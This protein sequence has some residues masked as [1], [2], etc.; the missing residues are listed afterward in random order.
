MR[1]PVDTFEGTLSLGVIELKFLLVLEFELLVDNSFKLPSDSLDL[2]DHLVLL[3]R[4]VIPLLYLL[5][6]NQ[7]VSLFPVVAIIS[8]V[9][10][11][12]PIFISAIAF[13]FLL[14]LE[15]QY[16]LFIVETHAPRDTFLFLASHSLHVRLN[17]TLH[18]L[19]KFSNLVYSLLH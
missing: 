7:L 6:V 8:T 15:C 4:Q 16:L 9:T 2:V 19:I 5:Q 3:I 10:F 11:V 18:L 17:V 14:L 1:L 13:F 12:R